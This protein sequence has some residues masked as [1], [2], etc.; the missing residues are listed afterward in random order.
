MPR[1]NGREPLDYVITVGGKGRRQ[2]W[3]RTLG[4]PASIDGLRLEPAD[5]DITAQAYKQRP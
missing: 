1:L 2:V 5:R 3:H 4:L